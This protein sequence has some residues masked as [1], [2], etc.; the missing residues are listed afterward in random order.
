MDTE[1][2]ASTP[3]IRREQ[4]F[5][6]RFP[7]VATLTIVAVLLD[8]GSGAWWVWGV[9]VL[10]LLVVWIFQTEPCFGLCGETQQ[11]HQHYNNNIQKLYSLVEGQTSQVIKTKVAAQQGYCNAQQTLDGIRL[12]ELTRVVMLNV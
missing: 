7:Y 5:R 10:P 6:T 3:N 4:W 1:A 9:N 8:I 12:L 11:E 2:S